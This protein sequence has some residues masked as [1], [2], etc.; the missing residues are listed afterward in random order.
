MKPWARLLFAFA[1]LAG[2]ARAAPV[3]WLDVSSEE[4]GAEDLVAEAA[5]GLPRGHPVILPSDLPLTMATAIADGSERAEIESLIE[6]AVAHFQDFQPE[7]AGALLTEASERLESLVSDESGDLWLQASWL[8]GQLAVYRGAFAEGFGFVKSIVW[9]APWWELPP[10]YIPP[11]WAVEEER[12]RVVALGSRIDASSLPASCR[13][14]IDGIDVGAQREIPVAPG[15]HTVR[16]TRPGYTDVHRIDLLPGQ[17]W[18]AAVPTTLQWDEPAREFLRGGMGVEPDNEVFDLLTALAATADVERIVVFGAVGTSG[19]L[20]AGFF[21]PGEDRWLVAPRLYTPGELAVRV[22]RE[23]GRS[24]SDPLAEFSLI[25]GVGGSGV[26]VA[27]SDA[28]MAGGGGPAVELGSS[29]RLVRWL[30]VEAACAASFFGPA[31]LALS[32]AAER[33]GGTQRSQLFRVVVTVGPVVPLGRDR[34]LWFAAGG[35]VAFAGITTRIQDEESDALDG[36]GGVLV[37]RLGIEMPIHRGISVSPAV[38]YIH[39]A[40]PLHSSPGTTP[41]IQCG[42]FRHLEFVLRFRL[43]PSRARSSRD[44]H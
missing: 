43:S 12:S 30:Q 1:A 27:S 2:P 28:T 34:H 36:R 17:R 21:E 4:D 22:E 41:T 6:R 14:S 20:E 25:A 5:A 8:Y 9:M 37:L 31:D 10:A 39:A 42:A 16:V 26:V 3:L 23:Q 11:E 40:I 13:V 19:A 38:S 33:L 15:H 32:E 24:S 18:Q 7:E 29:L 44:A 35:G